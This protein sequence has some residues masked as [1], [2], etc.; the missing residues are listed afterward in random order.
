MKR[1][2]VV[3]IVWTIMSVIIILSMLIWTVGIIF[4]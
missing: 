2:K 4:I 3:K 1:R